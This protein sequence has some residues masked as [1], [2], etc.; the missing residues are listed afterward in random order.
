M[1]TC[2]RVLAG[3]G[4]QGHKWTGAPLKRVL[5]EAVGGGWPEYAAN[6]EA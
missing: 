5:D 3:A 4:V 1:L 2:E 6:I